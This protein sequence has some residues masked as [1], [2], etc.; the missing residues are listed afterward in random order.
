MTNS[1]Y[2]DFILIPPHDST[3]NKELILNNNALY[4]K[5]L[6]RHTVAGRYP[7]QTIGCS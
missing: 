6:H 1:N 4:A 2:L 3:I 5:T 7:R